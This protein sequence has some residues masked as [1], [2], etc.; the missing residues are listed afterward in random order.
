MA[1]ASCADSPALSQL[2]S[3]P[4]ST[5]PKGMTAQHLNLLELAA[6]PAEAHVHGRAPARTPMAAKSGP[7][8]SPIAAVLS[9]LR[10]CFDG[11][12]RFEIIRRLSTHL[13][14]CTVPL[15]LCTSSR[16]QASWGLDGCR[17]RICAGTRPTA[18]TLCRLRPSVPYVR[19]DWAHRCRSAPSGKAGSAPGAAH[20]GHRR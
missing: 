12:L 4:P 11:A 19:G 5:V 7:F 1:A 16:P 20:N 18:A 8:A 6:I 2:L 3:Q 9:A 14:A 17:C 10:H 15:Q 13:I